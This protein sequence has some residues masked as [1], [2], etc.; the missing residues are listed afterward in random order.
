MEVAK[1]LIQGEEPDDTETRKEVLEF[2]ENNEDDTPAH[3]L[4]R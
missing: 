1:S 4:I 3:I 2:F